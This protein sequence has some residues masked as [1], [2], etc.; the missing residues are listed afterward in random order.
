MVL[1]PAPT[2]SVTL[3]S[4][5]KMEPY[6]GPVFGTD[7][8]SLVSIFAIVFSKNIV[9]WPTYCKHLRVMKE[10]SYTRSDMVSP[11]NAKHRPLQHTIYNETA[12]QTHIKTA[13]NN[14]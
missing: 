13:T 7:F 9:A 12:R 8:H 11:E 4:P 1:V 5:K 14:I 10:H 6:S 3:P 2:P